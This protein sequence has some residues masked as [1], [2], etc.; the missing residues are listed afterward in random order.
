MRRSSCSRRLMLGW[1][2]RFSE[3][4][5][6]CHIFWVEVSAKP[7]TTHS[8]AASH[9]AWRCQP[10]TTSSPTLIC[11]GSMHQCTPPIFS[12]SNE[13]DVEGWLSYEQVSAHIKWDNAQKPSYMNFYL[14]G[15]A[16]MWY[17]NH[18]SEL[19]T[20]SDFKVHILQV[21][22]R[23]A[24]PKLL[25]EKCLCTHSQQ[26][27]KN[28]TNYAEDIV[29]LCMHV[30]PSMTLRRSAMSWRVLKMLHFKC[31]SLNTHGPSSKSLNFV[32]VMTNFG[33]NGSFLD[34]LCTIHFLQA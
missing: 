30:D 3:V 25:A 22:S 5:I 18:E 7:G 8:D 17:H 14:K 10:N 24:V 20:W 19:R 23:T 31:S 13:Y 32:R 1:D 34:V 21:R 33:C 9:H 2:C 6:N 11:P 12:G 15:V 4:A 27:G 26:P 16:S 28:F 29:D